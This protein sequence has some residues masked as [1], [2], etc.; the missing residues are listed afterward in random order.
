[1]AKLIGNIVTLLAGS[2][3]MIGV[4]FA[5]GLLFVGAFLI[6]MTRRLTPGH[7]VQGSNV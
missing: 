4:L 1:M 3:L 6:V 5:V 2:I 7:S